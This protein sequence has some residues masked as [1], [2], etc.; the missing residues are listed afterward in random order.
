MSQAMTQPTLS[1]SASAPETEEAEALT[2]PASV[3]SRLDPVVLQ[4]FSRGDFHR[5][6]MRTIAKQAG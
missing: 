4:V 2:I 1:P 3:I 6:D 5:V